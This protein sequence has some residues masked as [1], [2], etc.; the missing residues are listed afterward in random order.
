MALQRR[1]VATNT[2]GGTSSLTAVVNK[3]TGTVSGDLIVAAI[4]IA[5]D[6]GTLTITPPSGWTSQTDLAYAAGGAQ[7]LAVFTKTAGGSE[8]STYSFTLSGTTGG[9]N[10]PW[11]TAA[12]SY[13][14]DTGASV[15]VDQKATVGAPGTDW[16]NFPSSSITP[17]S[18]N[19]RVISAFAQ[20]QS[21]STAF[22][23]SAVSPAALSKIADVNETVT[24]L[25][26]AL[27]EEDQT[28]AAAT[29]HTVSNTGADTSRG[30]ATAIVSI[31]EGGNS[32]SPS[33]GITLSGSNPVSI[34]LPGPTGGITF[35]GTKTSS[36]SR[37]KAVSG[38]L[39]FSGSTTVLYK[40][41]V[42]PAGTISFGGSV[43]ATLSPG[44]GTSINTGVIPGTI[45]LSGSI[46]AVFLG[47]GWGLVDSHSPVS[48]VERK[49]AGA[50]PVEDKPVHP[51]D[52]L[53]WGS[54]VATEPQSRT[55][56]RAAGGEA[57]VATEPDEALVIEWREDNSKN[58]P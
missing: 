11:C 53:P 6:V 36:Y 44:G 9:A 35:S 56:S 49:A 5:D 16:P 25:G 46:N 13:F 51:E 43:S 58:I 54:R 47:H 20:D 7:H 4:G 23:W 38:G 14:S 40:K 33:G 2:D 52:Q 8:P 57:T 30:V 21:G 42:S 41:T 34:T 27:F 55:A 45:S 26:L 32:V 39:T 22:T 24:N 31:K 17:G 18:N 28:T 19:E 15:I 1:A 3:P 29:T 50:P 48:R 10:D 37:S 12:A